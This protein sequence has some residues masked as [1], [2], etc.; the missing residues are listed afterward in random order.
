MERIRLRGPPCSSSSTNDILGG[1]YELRIESVFHATHALR[2]YDGSLEEPHAHDW[3]VFVEIAAETLDAIEVVM[4]F[5][6][7]EAIVRDATAD[8]EGTDL[9]AHAAFEGINPSAERVAERLHARIA[10]S[11]PEN[12]T[13]LRVT[14]TEAQGC[15][16]SYSRSN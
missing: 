10:P 16:A 3:R 11:M 2:L 8:L 13:R 14:V 12:I 1:M 15:R 6:A 4:D 7:L 9:N 5:H